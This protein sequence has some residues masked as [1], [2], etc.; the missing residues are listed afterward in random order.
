MIGDASFQRHDPF[1]TSGQAKPTCRS[2][3]A[4][5]P[6]PGGCTLQVENCVPRLD[7]TCHLL[8]RRHAC[9][10]QTPSPA[11]SPPIHTGLV[12]L[13]YTALPQVA[14]VIIGFVV[15]AWLMA[16]R[17]RSDWDWRLAWLSIVMAVIRLGLLAA[18]YQSGTDKDLSP[19]A[20]RRRECAYGAGSLLMAAVIAGM[21]LQALSGAD[22]GIQPLCLGL[23]MAT[24]T[25]QSSTRVVCRHGSRSAPTASFW[26]PLPEAVGYRLIS[27]T[28]SSVVCSCFTGTAT[29]RHV[30]TAPRPS[31]PCIAHR[32][33]HDDHTGASEPSRLSRMPIRGIRA[34]DAPQAEVRGF[35]LESR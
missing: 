8:A 13:L 1:K 3:K 30:A 17:T 35:C 29:S 16:W 5:R 19:A 12:R 31:W 2:S 27:A 6:P 28:R 4:D 24:F 11:R 25:G 9:L 14:S 18:F 15:G 10:A 21:S 34:L 26:P 23:T 20:A 33:A 22:A 7:G 32:A